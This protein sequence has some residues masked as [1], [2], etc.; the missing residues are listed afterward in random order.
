MNKDWNTIE[1]LRHI[2]H[3]WLNK[4][5]LIKGNLDL[6]RA[7]R[8]KE[9]I[10]DIIMEAQQEARLSNL[11]TPKFATLLLLCNWEKYNFHLEYEV[12]N[13]EKCQSLEDSTLTKWTILFFETLN[14][15]IK[16]FHENHLSVSIEPNYKGTRLF[17]D[18]SG[19]IEDKESLVIFMQKE[20]SRN[21]KIYHYE[22]LDNELIL[23]LHINGDSSAFLK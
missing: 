22:I 12:L 18:F 10:D 17:F 16:K 11:N 3:D 7:D 20:I 21:I 8:V 6:N 2:R 9:I 23:E 14:S 1:F 4:I 13:E 19:I 5:Q 15:G